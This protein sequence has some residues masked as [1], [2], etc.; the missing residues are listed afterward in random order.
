MTLRLEDP[1][2]Q[3]A[4]MTAVQ[5]KTGSDRGGV[6]RGLCKRF[7]FY[8]NEMPLQRNVKI[9]KCLNYLNSSDHFI[10]LGHLGSDQQII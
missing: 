7:R 10:G 6:G 3:E 2:G 9:Q 8:F 4:N 1:V 5:N